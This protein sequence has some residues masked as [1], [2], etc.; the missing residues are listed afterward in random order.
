MAIKAMAVDDAGTQ[1][2]IIGLTASG[3]RHTIPLV[4]KYRQL[5]CHTVTK[6]VR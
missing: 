6:Q 2:L 5:H 1:H 3:L 4:P